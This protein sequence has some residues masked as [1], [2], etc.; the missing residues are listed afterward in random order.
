MADVAISLPRTEADTSFAFP[1]RLSD[2][3]RQSIMSIISRSHTAIWPDIDTANF[4]SSQTLTVCIN[5]YYRH[6][7]SW[8]PT[9]SKGRNELD[10]SAPL[11]LAAMAAIG[12][13]YSRYDWKGLGIALGEL[14]RRAVVY[15]V[16]LA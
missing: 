8:L 16:R 15:I 14:V 11:L 12:A 9:I 4:P 2:E 5:L 13:T 6:F 10:E 7:H 3:C 1:D